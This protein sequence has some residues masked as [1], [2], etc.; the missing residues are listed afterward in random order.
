M[1]NALIFRQTL[2]DCRDFIAVWWLFW[3]I[4]KKRP[5][6]AVHPFQ[7]FPTEV[8]DP[9]RGFAEHRPRADEEKTLWSGGHS[10]EGDTP[11]M[12]WSNQSDLTRPHPK[13]WFS[14]GNPLISGKFRLVNGVAIGQQQIDKIEKLG[15]DPQNLSSSFLTVAVDRCHGEQ[16]IDRSELWAMVKLHERW[17]QT[18]LVTDS[19]Y[20][21]SSFKLVQDVFHEGQLVFRPNADLLIRLRRAQLGATHRVIKV[22]SHSLEGKPLLIEQ[23]FYFSLGNMVADTVAKQGNLQLC[24]PLVQQWQTE[25]NEAIQQQQLRK[26]HYELLLEVQP[27]RAMLEHNAKASRSQQMMLPPQENPHIPLA[28]QLEEWNPSPSYQFDVHWP[29]HL[30]LDGPWG[31]EI[32]V[33]MIQWWNELCWPMQVTGDID[34]AGISWAELTMDFLQNR[35][36]SIP[37]RHPY[38]EERSFQPNLYRLKQSGV[39]FFHVVK[40]FFYAMSWLNRR[41]GGTLLEGLRRTKVASLQ[42]Q[43]STNVHN[44]LVPRPK[45]THQQ[46]V[47][48]AISRYRGQSTV[49]WSGLQDWPWEDDFWISLQTVNWAITNRMTTFLFHICRCLFD[50][51]VNAWCDTQQCGKHHHLHQ[52]WLLM[53]V[54][55]RVRLTIM[56]DRLHLVVSAGQVQMGNGVRWNIIIWPVNMEPENTGPLEEENDLPNHWFFRFYASVRVA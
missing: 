12:L 36:M 42:R 3:V 19:A 9:S 14:K 29:L 23:S 1:R 20:V 38:S 48:Q 5:V 40:N 43:G 45:L 51:F 50:I 47:I 56:D 53:G 8:V 11:Q 49:R 44:G 22:Q 39:G 41:L 32:M 37:T 24:P 2:L 35:R 55:H 30:S 54:S 27:A 31:E 21:V 16:T 13:W 25:Y 18:T 10:V 46:T 34:R 52:F 33:N 15:M 7:S 4:S 26:A 17:K 28:Q 6:R